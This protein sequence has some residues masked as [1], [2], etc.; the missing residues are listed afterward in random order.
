MPNASEVIKRPLARD[1][2]NVNRGFAGNV[3][4]EGGD[5]GAGIIEGYSVIT[6]GEALGHGLWCDDVFLAQ[7]NEALA[8][9][10]DAGIKSRF[11]HPGLSADGLG[12]FLG[13]TKNPTLK[14]G[15]VVGDLHFSKSAHATP[16]GDL[17]S[18]VMEL[19]A[20]DPDKFGSSIVFE[21]DFPAE[22]QFMAD[23][24]DEAGRFKSPDPENVNHYPHC[25]LKKLSASD[26]VDDPAANPGGLFHRS[27]EIAQEAT[28]LMEYALDL[29]GATVPALGQ[30]DIDP[31]RLKSFL[32]R[33]LS[34]HGLKVSPI[35]KKEEEMTKTNTKP[36]ENQTETPTTPEPSRA[37]FAAELNKYVELFGA[38]NGG[39]WFAEPKTMEEALTA[40]VELLNKA[41]TAKDE[42]I[43]G[44]E[45][46][47]ASIDTGETEPFDSQSSESN[48]QT[49]FESLVKIRK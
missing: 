2:S 20:N 44:L 16:D 29:D 18:H 21:H 39:K 37:D 10:G 45:E 7:V 34:D 24:L 47:L 38:E 3:D 48:G 11:T 35:E 9:T 41:L 14:P 30:F 31:D 6:R 32:S 25:R 15:Q 40:Q 43:K 42:V 4:P 1:R 23:H 26:L 36:A 5:R 8:A 13:N 22:D 17:A 28:S 19:A 27:Q 46:K 33:F 49:T 12:K